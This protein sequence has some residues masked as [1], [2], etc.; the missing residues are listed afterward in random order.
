VLGFK[1]ETDSTDIRRAQELEKAE[2]FNLCDT[3]PLRTELG[4][5]PDC[6]KDSP[7]DEYLVIGNSKKTER[8]KRLLDTYGL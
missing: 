8:K 1:A 6:V 7:E 2:W 5:K 4:G 3:L